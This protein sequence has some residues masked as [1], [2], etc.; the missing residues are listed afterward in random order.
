MLSFMYHDCLLVDGT[1]CLFELWLHQR[2]DIVAAEAKMIDM[3]FRLAPFRKHYLRQFIMLLAVVVLTLIK[4]ATPTLWYTG[5][6]TGLLLLS[7]LP[8]MWRIREF[9][10]GIICGGVA[11]AAFYS[12][13]AE[14]NDILHSVW[15]W[16]VYLSVDF[17]D[18]AAARFPCDE[19]CTCPK[20]IPMAFWDAPLRDIITGRPWRK[21]TTVTQSQLY[22]GTDEKGVTTISMDQQVSQIQVQLGHRPS[23]QVG[24]VHRDFTVSPSP[25]VR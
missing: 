25:L 20:R 21:T 10:V 19:A 6:V 18:L 5:V 8:R 24:S 11:L 17:L 3:S 14:G 9:Q 23:V 13:P 15:H 2:M 22:L 7:A 1:T 12:E 4:I 16:F